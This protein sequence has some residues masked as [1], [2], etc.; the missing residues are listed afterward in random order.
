MPPTPPEIERVA[1]GIEGL[2]QVL[3]GGVLSDRIC[4]VRSGP[5]TGKTTLGFQFLLERLGAGEQPM[6][7]TLLQTLKERSRSAVS[8]GSSIRSLEVVE[9]PQEIEDTA[10]SEQRVFTGDQDAGH[11]AGHVQGMI[12]LTTETPEYGRPYRKLQQPN[13]D[14]FGLF[15]I[16]EHL[17]MMDGSTSVRTGPGEGCCVSL[18]LAAEEGTGKD[19]RREDRAEAGRE[20]T[21]ATGRE[22]RSRESQASGA[23]QRS[24]PIR[25]MLVED[26]KIVREGLM[27]IL[28][29]EPDIDPIAEAADGREA[30][31]MVDQ[32]RPDVVVMDVSMPRMDG[33]EATRVILADHPEVRVIGLS[34][35]ERED[36][37]RAM[38]DAG[39]VDYLTKDGPSSELV[40]TIRQ[41]GE[42]QPAS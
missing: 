18:R 1:T 8:L 41:H 13:T 24:R 23:G 20:E 37:D 35:H 36:L 40:S 2:D 42:A 39:A 16:K 34:M 33:V 26:H 32:A 12:N 15:S 10:A 29:A 17:S 5:G 22:H 30:V 21:E 28:R 31:E 6:C 9:L 4:R 27:G 38:K 3:G 25:V 11:D 19:S 14:G 7:V